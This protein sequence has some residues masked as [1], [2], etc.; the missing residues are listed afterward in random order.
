MYRARIFI[1]IVYF[2]L[3]SNSSF[4][5]F[6]QSS[7]F[8]NEIDVK[9]STKQIN[10]ISKSSQRLTFF[11][12]MIIIIIMI[13][14]MIIIEKKISKTFLYFFFHFLFHCRRINSSQF[15]FFIFSSMSTQ[16]TQFKNTDF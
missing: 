14:T 6:F 2:H 15:I 1:D 5:I 11:S 12:M 7:F 16:F 4:E 9:N 13:I 8:K 3:C 10:K